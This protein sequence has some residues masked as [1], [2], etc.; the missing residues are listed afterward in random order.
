MR[1]AFCDK[2]FLK[3][4]TM[5]CRKALL[6]PFLRDVDSAAKLSSGIRLCKKRSSQAV[7]LFFSFCMPLLLA[8]DVVAA[9]E[10]AATIS[11]G[12][13]A[14]R[15]V[16]ECLLEWSPTADYLTEHIPGISFKIIPLTFKE[17]SPAVENGRVDFVI[18]NPYVYVELQDL[19][20]VSRMVTLKRLT[21]EGYTSQFGGSIFCR[22]DNET[23]RVLDDLKNRSFAAVDEASFGGWM[24]A[25][26]EFKAAGID[27]YRDFKNLNFGGTQ[28][29]VVFAVRDGKADAGTVATPVLEEMIAEGKI[30]ADAFKILNRQEHKEYPYGLSTRLYPEWPF[31]RLKK[32][33]EDIAEKVAIALLAMPQQSSAAISS[34]VKGWTVPFDYSQVQ[35]CMQE[36]RVGIYKNFGIITI[37]DLLTAYRWK[38]LLALTVM[39]ILLGMLVYSLKLNRKLRISKSTLL[40]ETQERRRANEELAQANEFLQ[41]SRQEL[42]NIIDFLPD[43]T[44]VID[45]DKKVIT[46]NRAMEE[47]TGVSKDAMIGQGDLAYSVPFYGERREQLL[48]L[49]DCDDEALKNHYMNISRKGQAIYAEAFV[50]SLYAGKGAVVWA[51]SAPLFDGQG[52]YRGAIESIRDIT[53][54]KYIEE[55]KKRLQAQVLQTQKLES[56]GTLAGGIAH[57]FNNILSPIIGYT[58]MVLEA[59]PE[60]GSL[61]QD[62]GQ[63]LAGA[64][65]A[66]DLVKQILA[67]SRKGQEEPMAGVDISI[68]VKEALKLLRASLPSTIQITQNLEHGIA[69]VDATQ[70]HQVLV[71]LCTNAASA[72]EGKG[73]LDVSLVKTDLT[74]TVLNA[75]PVFSDLLPGQYLK[76][77]V[78]DTGH[79]IDEKTMQSIFEPYF[80]TKEV[81]KGTGLGLAVVHGIVK[82][83]GGEITVSSELGRGS[84]FSVYL[85]M[86]VIEAEPSPVEF[87]SLPRG[88]ERILLVDD[89]KILAEMETKMLEKLGYTVTAVTSAP[90]ALELF[91]AGASEFDVL[92]TDFT[93]PELTGLELADEILRIRPDIPVILC[94]GF[95]EKITEASM[96]KRGIHGPLMKPL[97]RGTV[98][99]LLRS[100]LDRER[101]FPE[102]RSA[103]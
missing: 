99:A 53:A 93:M 33:P 30:K 70:I 87:V 64:H 27:P 76:L 23:I 90:K 77:S 75:I 11:I 29:E 36:L 72:M 101:S 56:I 66:R 59:I 83:H 52:N 45:K 21:P 18:A 85:P 6:P 62:L 4:H 9:Q 100:V 57:D 34:R 41:Q 40:G 84:V 14:R 35:L 86:A 31:A 8:F 43:A 98:A 10:N 15:G 102:T 97:D 58:E 73:L 71:N 92:F 25:L 91:Q 61:K 3:R 50:P 60:M 49:V 24:V 94:T 103:A 12:V 95:S 13:L 46:W 38:S 48:D 28:D 7:V 55:E 54:Q 63:V 89:E 26:R 67:F 74:Q 69:I 96:K 5:V 79:G 42:A 81:G 51:T 82:R 22:A 47:M 16:A 32:T 80:T 65:R 20:G 17:I 88:T 19:Y 44:F 68:I 2:F 39:S 37:G 1:L 78:S